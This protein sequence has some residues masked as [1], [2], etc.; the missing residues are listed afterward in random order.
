MKIV[1]EE[2]REKMRQSALKNPTRYWLGKKMP[3]R[4][5]E[6]RKKM[7][8]V[9]IGKPNE[10]AWK[11]DLAGKGAMH[12]WIEKTFGKPSYCEI[13]KKTDKKKYE[14]A[15]KYH[16]YLRKA[17]DYF[18]ACSSCHRKY[19]IEHNNYRGDYKWK[20]YD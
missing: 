19:D 12:R 17:E 15:N 14:W 7:S 2:T 6:Y 5:N 1:T 11:G 10:G 18:R 9:K 13:C 3:E 16:T 4:S 8:L 20:K